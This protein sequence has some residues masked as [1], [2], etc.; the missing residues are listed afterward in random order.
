METV[1]VK[2]DRLTGKFRSKLDFYELMTDHCKCVSQSVQ[3]YLPVET[4]CPLQFMKEI[5]AGKK[6]VRPLTSGL[7]GR[8][9]QGH[10]HPSL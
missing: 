9:H 1:K 5:M 8:Q 6:L 2:S 7:Q 3:Y 10:E 4:Q